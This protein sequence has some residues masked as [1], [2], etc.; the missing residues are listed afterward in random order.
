[1]SVFASALLLPIA[2]LCSAVAFPAMLFE[3][4]LPYLPP[5]QKL[6]WDDDRSAFHNLKNISTEF[7]RADPQ[8][9]SKCVSFCV[10]VLLITIAIL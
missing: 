7:F 5:A 6:K 3:R 8:W 4:A 2:L 1:M 9:W 10:L